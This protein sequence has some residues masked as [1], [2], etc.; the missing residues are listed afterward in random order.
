MLRLLVE[1]TTQYCKVSLCQWTKAEAD[2]LTLQF[3][4]IPDWY[5]DVSPRVEG[6]ICHDVVDTL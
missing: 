3:S 2:Q 1:S 4:A 5:E 6:V